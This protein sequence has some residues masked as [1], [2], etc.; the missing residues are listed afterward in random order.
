MTHVE[1]PDCCFSI[2]GVFRPFGE[3]VPAPRMSSYIR[4]WHMIGFVVLGQ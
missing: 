3:G 2:F 1:L 4:I